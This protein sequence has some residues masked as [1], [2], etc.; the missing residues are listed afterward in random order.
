MAEHANYELDVVL[1]VLAGTG[2]LV[3]DNVDRH[4]ATA[5]VAQ[6][7]KGTT[8]AIHADAEGMAY[9]T[10]HRRRDPLGIRPAARP[11]R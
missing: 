2:R 3:V 6:I 4:V 8:R 5:V 1:I 10:V 11:P 9:L 7:P